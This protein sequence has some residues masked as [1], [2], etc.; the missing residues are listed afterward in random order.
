MYRMCLHAHT[1]QIKYTTHT[2]G[3]TLSAFV[4]T[5]SLLALINPFFESLIDGKDLKGDF[6]IVRKR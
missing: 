6:I 1:T 4:V 5:P 2:T 3:G